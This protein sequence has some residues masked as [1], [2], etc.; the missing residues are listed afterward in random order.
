MDGCEMKGFL[1]FLVLRIIHNNPSSGEDIRQ[2]IA[3]RKGCK[4]SAGTV[5]PV[6]KNFNE[7][8]FIKEIAEGGKERKYVLTEKGKKELQL[9]TTKFIAMFSDLKDEFEKCCK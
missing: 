9:A 8:G 3:K 5:Y 7:K 1:S 2:E 6:L 4:P